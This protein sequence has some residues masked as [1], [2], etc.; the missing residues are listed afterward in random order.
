M[1]G[2]IVSLLSG[3]TEILFA[4]GLGDRVAAVSH[5]CD[6]PTAAR[7]LPRATF[8]HIP[9]AASSAQIDRQLRELSVAGE[10]LYG[11]AADLIGRI[12]PDLIVTQ[13]QCDVCAVRYADVLAAVAA[14]PRLAGT[15]VLALNPLSIGDVLDDVRRI[16]E[17]AGAGEAA[18]RCVG[19]LEARINS[20]RIRTAA[21][22]AD[23]RPRAVCVEW[24]EPLMLAANWVPELIEMAGGENGLSIGGQHSTYHDWGSVAEYDPHT[25]IISP[26]GWDLQRSIEEAR[27]LAAVPVWN[28]LSAV[29][30]GRVFVVDGNAYLNRAGPRL[31]DTLEIL[32]HLL[33]PRV[34]PA[35]VHAADGWRQWS[36]ESV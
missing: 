6:W 29:R 7:E 33:H 8:S 14:D 15:K 36:L 16:G 21:L 19:D 31:V 10:P 2:R 34:H 20:V 4:L 30:A 25:I 17:A 23:Q 28:R 5:E 3:A 24:I 13:Q 18:E 26:C 27:V 22:S 35:P 12:A 1:S 32:A 9:A 11:L